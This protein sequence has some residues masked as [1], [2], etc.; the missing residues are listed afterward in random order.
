ML[1]LTEGE[2]T[3]DDPISDQ[4]DGGGPELGRPS[5]TIRIVER[6][7]G[8]ALRLKQVKTRMSLTLRFRWP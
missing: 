6:E 4:A 3:S 5:E 1:K 8:S 7:L 2:E